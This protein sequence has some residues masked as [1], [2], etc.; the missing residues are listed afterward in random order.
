[1]FPLPDW[2]IGHDY[3]LTA[4]SWLDGF[5]WF[6]NN[7]L[8]PP[9]FSPSFCAGQPF[10][11]DPQSSYYSIPQGLAIAFG[12]LPAAW[13]TLL[14]CAVAQ[15]WGGYRLMRQV[16]AS[17]I[18]AAILTGGL[19]MFNE[20]LPH[21]LMM[22]HLG[23]H[24]FALVP[25]LIL[26]L[27][28][29]GRQTLVGA[30]LILAYWVHSGFGGLMF[31]SL[32]TV[33][34][35]AL[36]STIPFTRFAGRA[37]IAGLI[38]L[39]LSASKLA[40]AGAFLAHFPRTFYALPGFPTPWEAVG[41]LA[42]SLFLP[43][44][45]AH[46]IAAAWMVHVQWTLAPHE[47]AYGFGAGA[48][49]AFAWPLIGRKGV[50][51]E[52]GQ[53]AGWLTG[54]RG[55]LFLALLLIPLAL[56]IW[57]S[58]WNAFLKSL[59]VIGQM[60][61]PLRGW[62]AYIPV[63]AVAAGLASEKMSPQVVGGILLLTVVLAA[64]APRDYYLS[65]NYDIRPVL[66]ADGALRTGAWQPAVTQLGTVAAMQD[67][68]FRAELR[69][70]DTFIA[71]MSQVFCYNPVFGYRLEKFSAEGLKQGPVLRE[72]DG[73]LN[74]KNPA[75]Y[76]FPKENHCVPGDR[77]RADQREAAMT[78]A[79]YR[80]FPFVVSRMQTLANA[81]TITTLTLVALLMAWL[82]IRA[83]RSRFPK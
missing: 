28:S 34:L 61:T 2:R 8:T 12:P 75:C 80:P 82:A 67:G 73:F 3:A 69:G 5:I 32:L 24:G 46:D 7:G 42:A 68:A 27:L 63:V 15:F 78:F 74:L 29:P 20:F 4:T 23:F 10:F 70:N 9:W 64:V 65:Q 50:Q 1:M 40:A 21:R 37:G 36:M 44:Q 56:S 83:M 49:L 41:A 22:G 33:S 71:G 66:V 55:A 25:W 57:Q 30:G 53:R 52:E 31:P 76:V 38:G 17:G 14:L 77:F 47:W 62:V 39:G 81:L 79:A 35:V 60:S 6:R 59:P 16:F 18:A 54:G 58:D 13:G 19:L 43:S 72:T 48:L 11:A 26:W 45:W 51:G